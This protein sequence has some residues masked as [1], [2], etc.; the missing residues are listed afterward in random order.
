MD[1]ENNRVSSRL[2]TTDKTTSATSYM[3]KVNDSTDLMTAE[4]RTD[5]GSDELIFLSKIAEGAVSNGIEKMAKIDKDIL[6]VELKKT[7]SAQY[8][9]F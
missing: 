9:E 3:V 1:I 7:E 2:K 5:G 4:G 8:F 6:Q